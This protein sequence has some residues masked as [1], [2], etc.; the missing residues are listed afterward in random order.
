MTG[1]PPPATSRSSTPYV[2]VFQ[3]RS[4]STHLTELLDSHP[5]IHAQ[6]E[7][8]ATLVRR[9][10]KRGWS[11]T[12]TARAQLA[13][14]D[15]YYTSPPTPEVQSW[16]F[17]TKFMDI[18]DRDGFAEVL[19][20][21]NVRL[22]VLTRRN[23]VKVVVSFLNALRLKDATG[24]WNLRGD[25]E[26]LPAFAVDPEEF[27]TWLRRY[28]EALVHI[29]HFADALGQPTLEL[30]YEDLLTAPDPT[31]ERLCTFLGVP[32]VPMR[33]STRKNT[34]DELR[35]VVIN[36]DELRA[37]YRESPYGPMFDEVLLSPPLPTG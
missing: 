20:K 34:N 8:F 12:E 19:R 11:P 35:R 30:E 3:A 33:S 37:R 6:K 5:A 17:K 16:G 28:D 4:G 2:L 14:M 7:S 1:S 13:W 18:V 32:C 23:R 21:R 25:T 31:L 10:R 26:R 29:K 9:G 24:G 22:V 27:D 15:D 36:F